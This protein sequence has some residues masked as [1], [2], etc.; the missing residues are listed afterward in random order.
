V[1]TSERAAVLRPASGLVPTSCAGTGPLTPVGPETGSR[2]RPRQ[3]AFS[4]SHLPVMAASSAGPGPSQGMTS[5]RGLGR[6][7]VAREA[8]GIVKRRM[9]VG[10]RTPVGAGGNCLL[11]YPDIAEQFVDPLMVNLDRCA[12]PMHLKQVATENPPTSI[13]SHKTSTV[14]LK[15]QLLIFICFR[16]LLVSMSDLRLMVMTVAF[17]RVGGK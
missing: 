17:R 12:W 4:S 2:R 16:A 5:H 10:E 1:S 8:R 7:R 14:S 3:P 15:S 11:A 6:A 13:P 9:V